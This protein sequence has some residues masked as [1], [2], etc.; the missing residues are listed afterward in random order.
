METVQ[1]PVRMRQHIIFYLYQAVPY[2]GR[3]TSDLTFIHEGNQDFVGPNK[4]INFGKQLLESS[5]Y[6]PYRE[7]TGHCQYYTK[8]TAVTSQSI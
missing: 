8:N 5:F 6:N 7:K 2:L 1:P 4:L 3:L